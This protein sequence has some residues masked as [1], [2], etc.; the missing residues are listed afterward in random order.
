MRWRQ[1]F[2]S[3]VF[4]AVRQL[5]L[6]A[7]PVCRSAGALSVGPFPAII[8][9]TEFPPGADGLPAWDE[10]GGDLTLAVRVECA[11]CGYLML[12]NSERFRSAGE[13]ILELEAGE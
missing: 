9:R 1:A 5:G 4:Q 11:T 8:I 12:F 2:M 3:E 6:Q 7:C 10:P 13:K